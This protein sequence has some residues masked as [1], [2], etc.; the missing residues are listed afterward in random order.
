MKPNNDQLEVLKRYI[1]LI[2]LSLSNHYI[3]TPYIDGNQFVF[4]IKRKFHI[5]NYNN[6]FNVR[7]NNIEECMAYL[8]AIQDLTYLK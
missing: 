8:N 4:S 2:N 1:N 5:K 6:S 7:R 3:E